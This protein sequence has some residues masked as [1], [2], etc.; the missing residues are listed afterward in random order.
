MEAHQ[1]DLDVRGRKARLQ[2]GLARPGDRHRVLP[3]GGSQQGSCQS[4][5]RARR[6]SL[7]DQHGRRADARGATASDTLDGRPGVRDE[8]LSDDGRFLYAID[9]YQGQI[10]G[11]LVDDRGHLSMPG[12]WDGVPTTVAGLAAR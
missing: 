8:G 4:N 10:V 9:A 1:K 12:A 5:P 11:W 6:V 2:A 7:R 3:V